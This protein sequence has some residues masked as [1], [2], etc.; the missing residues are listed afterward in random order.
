MLQEGQVLGSKYR[1]DKFLHNSGATTVWAA[2][3]AD[4][5]R[6]VALKVLSDNLPEMPEAISRFVQDGRNAS[7]PL[8]PSIVR[9]EEV[10]HTGRGIPFMVMELLDGETL[11]QELNETGVLSLARAVAVMRMVLQSLGEAHAKGACHR[12]LKP[13]NIFLPSP[14]STGPEV[15]ILNFGVSRPMIAQP[16][17]TE[18]KQIIGRLDFVA[19]ELLINPGAMATPAADVFSC[20]VLFSEALTGNLPLKPLAA[21]DQAIKQKLAERR[22][23]Y[24]AG[25][26]VPVPASLLPTLPPG[27]NAVIAQATQVDPKSR[28]K[29]AAEMNAALEDAISTDPALQAATVASTA[30]E[31]EYEDG[32]GEYDESATIIEA[33]AFDMEALIAARKA[34]TDAAA[35]GLDEARTAL[36]DHGAHGSAGQGG[37]PQTPL[38]DPFESGPPGAPPRATP[39]RGAPPIATPPPRAPVAAGTPAPVV[40]PGPPAGQEQERQLG[41]VKTM[42]LDPNNPPAGLP[43]KRPSAPTEK[44]G[45]Q[46]GDFSAPQPPVQGGLKDAKTMLYQAPKEEPEPAKEGGGM[47]ATM[48]LNADAVPQQVHEMIAAGAQAPGTA[49]PGGGNMAGGAPGLDGWVGNWK[50]GGSPTGGQAAGAGPAKKKGGVGKLILIIVLVFLLLGVLAGV[51]VGVIW[52]MSESDNEGAE[53]S[54]SEVQPAPSPPASP[55]PVAATPPVATPAPLPPP[56]AV[57]SFGASGGASESATPL[58]ITPPFIPSL[59]PPAAAPAPNPGM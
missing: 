56:P 30:D 22:N 43:K 20:G 2:T 1:L 57:P 24:Q 51:A 48:M 41:D 21:N 7:K 46:G 33:P 34:E 29:N 39:P 8:H 47:A 37:A 42:L 13:A 25:N 53:S 58:T 27:V 52:M 23:F 11:R 12:N 15:R 54:S 5:Q 4:T 3:N 44:S 38:R 32:E 49:P 36:Y 55:A 59:P 45:S 18:P 40:P 17:S 9:V 31:Y 50:P 19:P 26:A 16:R 14:E 35:K 10:G 28:F 6:K